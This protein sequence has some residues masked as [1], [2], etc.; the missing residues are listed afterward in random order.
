MTINQG[1]SASRG[2]GRWPVRSLTAVAVTLGS[3]AAVPGTA[4]ALT[5]CAGGLPSV[6]HCYALGWMGDD[7]GGSAIWMNAV[8]TDLLVSCLS[9]PDPGSDFATY[10]MWMG[11]NDNGAANT[12]VEEGMND[13]VGVDGVNHGFSWFWADMRNPTPSTTA[14]GCRSTPLP[15]SASTGWAAGTGTSS[16]AAA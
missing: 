7:F 8:G 13:G 12:W 5:G 9:V 14:R 1:R 6:G 2:W 16:A 3:L 15:M 11:T 4:N 10:E